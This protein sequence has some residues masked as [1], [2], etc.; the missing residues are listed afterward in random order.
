MGA[1][2]HF[3]LF[4]PGSFMR[5][6]FLSDCVINRLHFLRLWVFPWVSLSAAATVAV[7]K[8]KPWHNSVT[9]TLPSVLQTQMSRWRGSAVTQSTGVIGSVCYKVNLGV[10]FC[11]SPNHLEPP[12][13]RCSWVVREGS[14]AWLLPPLSPASPIRRRRKITT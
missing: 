9:S 3:I 14:S 1:L 6:L 11:C 5:G 12:E 8:P 4:H 13:T 2:C 10:R 7:K